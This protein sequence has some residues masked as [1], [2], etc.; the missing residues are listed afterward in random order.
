MYGCN[1]MYFPFIPIVII[2]N[3]PILCMPVEAINP[4][5]KVFIIL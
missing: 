5:H 3:Y 4:C 2:N 1:G